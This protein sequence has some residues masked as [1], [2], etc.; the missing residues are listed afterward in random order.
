MNVEYINPF[1]VASTKIISETTGLTP[2]LGK[3]YVKDIPYNGGNVLVLIGLTG[4]I[5]GCAVITFSTEVACKIASAMM[6]GVV[7][8][9]LDEMAKSALGE[10]CNMILGSTATLFSQK[11][12]SIDITPPTIMTGDNIQLTPHKSVIVCVPLVFEDG[13]ALEI[14]ISYM[15]K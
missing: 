15:D 11:G 4:K 3:V 14:D 5:S 2:K 6:M 12:I 8:T 9:E 7:V 10:L 1:I 13:K